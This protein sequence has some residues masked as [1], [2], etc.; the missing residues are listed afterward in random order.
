M[1][2]QWT[3]KDLFVLCLIKLEPHNV[4]I[5]ELIL[6]IT[7]VL[8]EILLLLLRVLIFQGQE[9]PDL[10]HL[11]CLYWFYLEY[12]WLYGYPLTPRSPN[13]S[14]FLDLQKITFHTTLRL[15]LYKLLNWY[16][17]N[18]L[19]GLWSIISTHWRLFF[20][21]YLWACHAQLSEIYC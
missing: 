18:I 21:P 17:D 6:C 3:H 14:M 2:H 13:S 20:V 15:K 8:P 7:P 19:G 12:L 4:R 16:K 9:P 1:R 10:K 11:V 5:K